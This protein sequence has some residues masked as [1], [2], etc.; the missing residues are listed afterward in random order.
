MRNYSSRNYLWNREKREVV[1]NIEIG[2]MPEEEDYE[3]CPECGAE[4][5]DCPTCGE[6]MKVCPEC[7]KE[8]GPP[9]GTGPTVVANMKE[10]SGGVS[11][12]AAGK[13]GQFA[14][15]GGHVPA[16]ANKPGGINSPEMQ[17]QRKGLQDK[18]PAGTN[19]YHYA[20]AHMAATAAG[21]KPAA[22][23]AYAAASAKADAN[24]SINPHAAGQAALDAH[25]KAAK[26]TAYGKTLIAVD[27]SGKPPLKEALVKWPSVKK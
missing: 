20:D 12:R 13:G 2:E 9:T 15:G 16:A 3:E 5:P 18:A 21:H 11:T 26:A 22:A 6:T 27:K 7:N 23:H 4:M 8:V 17:A 10:T 25:V 1:F 14:K 19:K 24:G